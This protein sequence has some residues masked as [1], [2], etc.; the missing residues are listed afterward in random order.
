MAEIKIQNLSFCYAGERVLENICL[1]IHQG[2]F[3]GI[4]GAN[5]GGKSTL[6]KLILG[7]LPCNQNI[8]NS[9]SHIAY[10]PQHTSANP[11]FPLRVFECVLMGALSPIGQY[12]QSHR[13]RALES[14]QILK[15]EHLKDKK[16]QELSGGQRQKALIAR[17]ICTQAPLIILDEP[18]ASLDHSSTQEIFSLLHHLNSLGITIVTIC[19][20]LELLLEVSTHIAHLQKTLSLYTIPKE[21]Q[22]LIEDFGCKHHLRGECDA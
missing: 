15:I 17:A 8:Y 19:H 20:D 18:T 7:L 12:T 14:M 1:Q 22:Q 10:V 13:Q 16:M 6:L 4:I 21:S 9:F 3:L 11:F 5:G 2:D